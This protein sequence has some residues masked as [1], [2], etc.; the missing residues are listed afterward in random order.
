MEVRL[1]RFNDVQYRLIQ[2]PATLPL[3]FSEKEIST[4]PGKNSVVDPVDKEAQAA[5][6]ERKVRR[7][8]L[9]ARFFLKLPVLIPSILRPPGSPYRTSPMPELQPK[10][11]PAKK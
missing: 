10:N 3:P 2:R 6:V 11:A 7:P 9:F 8:F 4:H 1:S 5:D